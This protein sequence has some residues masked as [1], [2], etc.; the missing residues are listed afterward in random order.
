MQRFAVL[1]DDRREGESRSERLGDAF[2]RAGD[3]A[4][5]DARAAE[6]HG[7]RVHFVADAEGSLHLLDLLG[8]LLFAH[9]RHGEHQV[10]RLVVVQQGGLDAQ[11][12]RQ[13]ELRFAAVGRQVV[14]FA[15]L[16]DGL[17]QA[18][19]EGGRREGLRNAYLGAQLAERGLRTGPDDV[20]DGEVV[21]VEGLL[22]R[23]GVDQTHQ[24]GNVESEVVEERRV[25]A[26]IV[27]VVGVVVRCGG[28]SRKQDD[29]LPDFRAQHLAARDIGFC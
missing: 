9:L 21:A 18:R 26:E 7:Q 20:L 8:A 10:H 28:V 17:A 23:V 12:F 22:A 5:N 19:L 4:L 29:A 27:G 24:R 14:D 2:D 11:Q 13:L 25:L 16:G 15:P 1:R 6:L 3:L